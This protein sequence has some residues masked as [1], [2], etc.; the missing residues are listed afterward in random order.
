MSSFVKQISDEF[1]NLINQYGFIPAKAVSG[2]RFAS[3]LRPCTPQTFVYLFV[4]DERSGS[5]SLNVTI[6]VAPLELPDDAL[7]NLGI[8]Y[9]I[10]MGATYEPGNH[11]FFPSMEQR[12]INVLPSLESLAKA[13]ETELQKPPF[14]TRRFSV[15]EH[16][17]RALQELIQFHTDTPVAEVYR[18]VENAQQLAAGKGKLEGLEKQVKILLPSL[19]SL[20]CFAAETRSFFGE[21]INFLGVALARRLYVEELGKMAH[22]S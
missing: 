4:R 6:W 21:D 2:K 14:Q 18:V 1:V 9:Q 20:G 11:H 12:I 22:R 13:V 8:G 17:K 7:D 19:F 3:L 5:G 16:E 15:Y 10:L